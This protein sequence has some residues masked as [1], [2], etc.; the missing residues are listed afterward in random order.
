VRVDLNVPIVADEITDTTR[1][2]RILPTLCELSERGG[3]VILLSHLGRPMGRDPAESLAPVSGALAQ[4]LGREIRFVDDCIGDGAARAILA[5]GDGDILCLENTRFHAGEEAN[6]PEFARELARLG[7]VYVNDAFSSAHRAHASTE[8]LARLLP[9]F[10]GRTMA[11]ELAALT[12]VLEHPKRPLMAIV[13]GA[14]ISTK[15][16]LIGNLIETV[17]CLVVGGGM[18]NTFLAAQGVAIGASL[19]ERK[20]VD[21]AGEILAK[22]KARGCE[23]LLPVD[24]LLAREYRKD[25]S[26][27]IAK[28]DEVEPDEMILD[29]GPA[30][31]AAISQK[32][33]K[34]ATLVWNGPLGAFEVPPFDHGSVALARAV[35]ERVAAR[36]LIAVA[37]GGDTVSVLNHAG[38]AGGMSYVSTAGGAFLEWLEGKVLPGVAA[39]R[40]R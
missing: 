28:I 15:L 20:L 35:A 40:R 29:A 16:A 23:I 12:A 36:R 14:K 18:A 37:G 26:W 39:L 6:D 30:S 34:V 10:A 3:R 24:A 27:R 31:I 25:A 7:D 2:S 1:L 8:A 19:V 5:M 33:D 11:K 32:L 38:L 13:G 21:V 22:A 4:C 9:G 17:D